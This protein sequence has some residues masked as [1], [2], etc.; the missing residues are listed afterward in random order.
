MKKL[1]FFKSTTSS[2][3]TS[4]LAPTQSKEKQL[5]SESSS[6]EGIQG[7]RKSRSKKAAYEDQIQ[8][9]S[10]GGP[11]LRK[12]RSY[13]SSTVHDSGLL[14]TQS[15]SPCSSSSNVSHKHSASRSSR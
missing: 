1:F 4:N 9:Q 3:G 14:R 10:Q 5:N 15:D 13:S 11:F 2:S 6:G 12:S 7:G 8:N